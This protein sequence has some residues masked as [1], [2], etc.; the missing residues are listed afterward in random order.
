MV[1]L[2]HIKDRIVYD[3][4]SFQLPIIQLPI[5]AT[6]SGHLLA[7]QL[8][9]VL[10]LV[11]LVMVA[12]EHGENVGVTEEAI[13]C[14][15]GDWVRAQVLGHGHLIAGSWL[16]RAAVGAGAVGGAALEARAATDRSGAA[17]ELLFFGKGLARPDM[18]SC[19]WKKKKIQL[20]IVS[21]LS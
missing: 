8:L 18:A 7:E 15:C 20:P 17:C 11:I 19:Y 2:N 14:H 10:V 13:R 21:V 6:Q 16:W 9:M 12:L 1:R 5:S 4:I 3:S